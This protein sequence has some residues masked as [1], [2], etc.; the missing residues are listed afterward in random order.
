MKMTKTT[1]KIDSKERANSSTNGNPS[2]FVEATIAG[3]SGPLF[4]SGKTATDASCGY[5][6]W[7]EGDSAEIWFHRTATG[8]VVFDHIHETR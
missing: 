7:R 5:G 4:L 1:G 8:N 2:Y 6:N 3:E